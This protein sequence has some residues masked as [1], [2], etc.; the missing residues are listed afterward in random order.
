[1]S[2]TIQSISN[3]VRKLYKILVRCLEELGSVCVRA[4]VWVWATIVFINNGKYS[5]GSAVNF[6]T[7]SAPTD[8]PR[9]TLNFYQG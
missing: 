3:Y 7:I 2:F 1:M 6:F 8:L 5:N 9:K 4:R